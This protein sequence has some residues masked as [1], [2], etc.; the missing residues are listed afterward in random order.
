MPRLRTTAVLTALAA[1]TA[2]L[3]TTTPA[4]AI[5]PVDAGVE[6]SPVD[7]D[8]VITLTRPEG[9]GSGDSNCTLRVEFTHGETY[10]E[11][12]TDFKGRTDT[13]ITCTGA[14]YISVW[15]KANVET[16][17][18]DGATWNVLDSSGYVRHTEGPPVIQSSPHVD[19]AIS[20]RPRFR[21]AG[22]WQIHY[23]TDYEITG[24]SGAY[25]SVHNDSNDHWV[26]CSYGGKMVPPV[27]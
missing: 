9:G 2:L 3:T 23:P 10:Y 13:S 5:G 8:F 15:A 24:F 17:V 14:T 27:D 16:T 11:Y 1:A 7:I 25:C 22:Y 26:A 4:Q 12:G 21:G 6:L 20:D 18:D 19:T